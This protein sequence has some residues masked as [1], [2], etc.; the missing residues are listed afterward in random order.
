MDLSN[1]SLTSAGKSS[2]LYQLE[3]QVFFDD[4]KEE[5]IRVIGS[6]DNMSWYAFSPLSESF[7]MS[8]NGS[9]IN[10]K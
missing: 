6:I 1:K 2:T 8:P 5:N 7:I 9:L 4:K 3:I 10:G